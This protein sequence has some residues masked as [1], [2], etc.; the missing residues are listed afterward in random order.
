MKNI[1]DSLHTQLFE[2]LKMGLAICDME[3]NLVFINSAYAN[4]L[5]KSKEE[6]LKLTYWEITP[7]KYEQQEQEQLK[8]LEET[9]EYGPYDKEYIHA[10]GK[11]I[12]VRLNGKIIQIDEV[13]YIW[14]SVEDVTFSKSKEVLVELQSKG[15]LIEHAL[16][17]IFVF[18]AHSLKFVYVNETAKRNI[19]Y[20]TKELLKMT[21]LD[22][23]P[24]YNLESFNEALISLRNESS[25]SISFDTIHQR[26]DGTKYNV[27]VRVQ[28]GTYSAKDVFIA[29]IIDITEKI[30]MKSIEEKIIKELDRA[31]T[32]QTVIQDNAAYSIIA[33][34]TKGLITNFNKMAQELLGYSAEEMLMKETPAKFHDMDEIVEKTKEFSKL[35]G[36]EFEPGFRTLTILSDRGLPNSYEW[37]YIRKDGT[38]VPVQL[39]ITS[40]KDKTGKVTGYLG[41]AY[42]I[43]EQKQREKE[44]RL[45][46]EQAERAVIA[47]TQFLANMSHEIRTPLNGIIGMTNLL[48]D[49]IIDNKNLEDI[50]TLQQSTNSLLEIVNDIL[51]ISKIEAGKVNLEL[52]PFNLKKMIQDL[53]AIHATANL[54]NNNSLKL[55]YD[56]NIPKYII[57]DELRIKQV[58]N[59]LISN[60]TKFT[61]S[62]EINLEIEL[63]SKE[64]TKCKICFKIKDTGIGI[65]KSDLKK[66]FQNFSQ[67][68][69]STTRKFG[70]T[71]LGL[72][73]TKNLVELL[74]GNIEVDSKYNVG[75]TFSFELELA[76]K[77]TVKE[78]DK[79]QALSLNR[80]D[81]KVLTVDDNNINRKVASSILKKIGLT[82]DLAVNGQEALERLEQSSYDLILMDCHMPVLDGFESTKK[83][84]LRYEGKKRPIII[85]V[86]A[87]AMQSDIDKCFASGMDD[88]I[89]KPILK[90]S[91]IKSINK[92]FK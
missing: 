72:S 58:L 54:E 73:I 90:E 14:S 29:F 77:N 40:L 79:E 2:T 92:F 81:L 48:K 66:L 64:E 31:Y 47:K 23:K 52:K 41:I 71:G 57:S 68:D 10:S 70:G 16:N 22:I 55:N 6:V 7:K 60:S 30:K 32:F 56:K 74:G 11:L 1:F 46:K 26:K 37:T 19:G 25:E 83:I 3:G 39:N 34:T 85:A 69:A 12:P 78:Q 9:G 36:E 75:T 62:G 88:F 80:T 4:L 45:A 67:A 89:S 84:H 38:R 53:R 63:I 65:K 76:Y 27:E 91:L 51:D 18:D 17:E 61:K 87:S 35:V 24:Q 49:S 28:R 82:T 86:T 15:H 20:S 8:K 33:T 13:D 21:P 44:L 42:D 43:S 50:E 59:N 5:G